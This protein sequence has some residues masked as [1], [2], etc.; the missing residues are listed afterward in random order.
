MR[1][2]GDVDFTSGSFPD[3]I[4]ADSSGP[5]VRDGT[6]L[7]AAWVSDIWLAFQAMLDF[8]GLT[9]NGYAENDATR[10]SQ[11]LSASRIISGGPGEVIFYAGADPTSPSGRLL[12]LAGQVVS[13]ADYSD[14]VAETYCGDAKNATAVNF[15]KSSDSGGTTRSTSGTYFKLPDCRGFFLRGIGDSAGDIDSSRFAL[16][17][18]DTP[19][20]PQVSQSGYHDHMVGWEDG[21]TLRRFTNGTVYSFYAQR[22]VMLYPSGWD[23]TVSTP[24]PERSSTELSAGSTGV[25]K[26]DGSLYGDFPGAS[27]D[28]RES[29]SV[30]VGFYVMIRY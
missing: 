21:S 23:Y 7:T 5:T 4:A 6:P 25:V 28:D 2:F 1:D 10:G 12:Q 24:Y 3:V 17:L 8:A 16:G 27:S 14:L 11:L 15:Y 19:G 22:D 18:Y 30:N 26:T 13:V 20:F 29:R 9:P